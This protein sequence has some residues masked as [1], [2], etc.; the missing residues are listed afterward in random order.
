MYPSTRGRARLVLSIALIASL[1]AP[2]GVWA[3]PS[4]E[5]MAA[6][7]TYQFSEA[8]QA[9][10]V[11]G[12]GWGHGVG[13]CQWGTRGRALAGQTAEQIVTAYYLGTTVTRAVAGD[14]TVRVLLDEDRELEEG[15]T[16]LIIGRGGPWRLEIGGQSFQMPVDGTLELSNSG[17]TLRYLARGKDGA[18][19]SDGAFRTA[20]LRPMD[21]NTRFTLVYKPASEVAGR[22]GNY[23][24]TYRGE[25]HLQPDGATWD[26]FNR[27]GM[28]D[29]LRGVV[30]AEMPSSWPSEALKA[31]VLAARSYAVWHVRGRASL[32]YDVNDT[33]QF[34]VYLGSN[35]ERDNV[36]R[37]IDATSGQ[38]V[39][40]GDRVAQTYF[41]STCSGWTEDNEAVWQ[42]GEPLPYLRAIHDVDA[43]GKPYDTDSPVFSWSTGALTAF[44]LEEMLNERPETEVGKLLS[45]EITGRTASGRAVRVR[46]TGTKAVRTIAADTLMARFNR[47][48][49][50]GVSQM[51]STNFELKWTTLDAVRQTQSTIPTPGPVATVVAV[52]GGSGTAPRPTPGPA[53]ATPAPTPAYFLEYTQPAAALP[54]GPTNLYFPTT[55]H[56]VGGAF[57]QFF[58]ANGGVDMFGYPRTE[59]VLEDGRTVQY[60][61]RARLEFHAD[62]VGTPYEV[63]PGLLG[64]V[65]AASRPPFGVAPLTDSAPGRVFFPETKHMLQGGFLEFWQNNGGL[66]LFGYPISE[67]IYENGLTV[68]YFQRARFEFYPDNPDGRRVQLGL[69]GDEVLTK[70]RWLR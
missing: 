22:P 26:T 69:L 25:I 39:M 19:I 36:N 70:R 59:P 31:Q 42:G 43:S 67:E 5:G 35:I 18:R 37:L 4:T 68:Q 15:K 54:D 56:N 65:V 27:V 32:R 13:M 55:G 46:A 49:P 10:V 38:I 48:R 30:P 53:A 63:Q 7:L 12:K 44:Q 41:S 2:A 20:A 17:G 21:G 8:N 1:L 60:F 29:Y 58:D 24:D 11:E 50:P 34:Q 51:L 16:A 47:L 9:F 62:K 33:T 23:Y 66:D 52:P 6:P 40:S 45:L 28:D 61:Q 57:L 3:A 64:D 14:L